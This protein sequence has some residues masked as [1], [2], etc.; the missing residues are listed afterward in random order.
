MPGSLNYEV[1]GAIWLVQQL[2]RESNIVHS[3]PPAYLYYFIYCL[4]WQNI[5]LSTTDYSRSMIQIVI[6]I[7][8]FDL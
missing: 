4:I 1:E 5:F 6:F 2:Q 7:A 3:I 8:D